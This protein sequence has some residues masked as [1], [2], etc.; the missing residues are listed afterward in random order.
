MPVWLRHHFLLSVHPSSHSSIHLTS[1]FEHYVSG[2]VLGMNYTEKER[3]GSWHCVYVVAPVLS[4]FMVLCVYVCTCAHVHVGRG[5]QLQV[6]TTEMIIGQIGS[7]PM[8]MWRKRTNAPVMSQMVRT[9]FPVEMMLKMGLSWPWELKVSGP[10]IFNT[11]G[12]TLIEAWKLETSV[13][14]LYMESQAGRIRWLIR[15]GVVILLGPS[16]VEREM[17]SSVLS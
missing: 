11:N 15:A 8:G 12:A 17:S 7:S 3:H 9:E 14:R 2:T 4:K 6:V 16:L 13:S 5:S 10:G 1:I